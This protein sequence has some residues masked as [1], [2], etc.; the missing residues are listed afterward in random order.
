MCTLHLYIVNHDR[1]VS[2]PQGHISPLVYFPWKRT[3]S[4]TPSCVHFT[5]G[6]NIVWLWGAHGNLKL[7]FRQ[8]CFVLFGVYQSPSGL[9]STCSWTLCL[10]CGLRI[11][12]C[13]DDF[14]LTSPLSPCVQWVSVFGSLER[15]FVGQWKHSI[16]SG[17]T[18]IKHG[19][20]P[21]GFN[22]WK[23]SG[24]QYSRPN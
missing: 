9:V 21:E 19:G 16:F 24:S 22:L 14:T 20:R 3:V 11:G 5:L 18:W 2:Q 12:D 10:Y 15:Q 13:R 8:H 17:K 4:G 6:Y 23:T 1:D 7:L